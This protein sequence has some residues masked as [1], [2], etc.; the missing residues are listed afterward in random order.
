MLRIAILAPPWIPVPPP[1]Y[2]GIESVVALLCDGLVSRGHDVTLYAAPGSRSSAHVCTPLPRAH[3]DEIGS[4]LHESDHV[5]LAWADIDARGAPFD[6]VQDHSGYTA[7]A[8]ADRVGTPVVH[9]IHGPLT[10]DDADFYLR[11]GHKATL[12]AISQSQARQAPDAVSIAAVV[13]N[14]IAVDRWPFR[15]DK[16]DYLLWMGRMEAIKGPHRAIEAARLADL[17]LVLAGP[18]QPGQHDYFDE[19]IAPHLDGRKV[20][21]VG[22]VAGVAKQ[23]LFARAAAFLMPIRWQEPFGMVMVEALAC[24]TPVIAFAEGAASEIVIDGENGMLV[25]DET[26]MARAARR[27]EAIDPWR[28]RE[29][30]AERYDLS[31][32]VAGYE[33]A[34]RRAM[35]RTKAPPRPTAARVEPRHT[36][37][38]AADPPLARPVLERR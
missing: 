22:E 23:M 7:L 5:A 21:Y 12:V 28:C 4:A 30:V 35:L 20:R 19:Q 16:D 2:G 18:V 32:V 33:A 25:A 8:M 17:P 27:V 1:G 36:P 3:P 31:I 24:G 29:S 9:T 34:Y 15:A 38:P 14:P 37:G 10:G 11:H 26:E 13:P 6:I